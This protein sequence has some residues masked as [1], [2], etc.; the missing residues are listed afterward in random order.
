MT[1]HDRLISGGDDLSLVEHE[2][3]AAGRGIVSPCT[4]MTIVTLPSSSAMVCWRRRSEWTSSALVGSSSAKIRFADEHAGDS[5][6]L[7][8]TARKAAAAR[9]ELGVVAG[10]EPFDLG[11]DVRTMGGLDDLLAHDRGAVEHDVLHD[12]ALEEEMGVLRDD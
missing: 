1:P 5:E 12:R 9:P 6:T 3:P 4:T 10:G 7:A 2:Q 11:G 8:L